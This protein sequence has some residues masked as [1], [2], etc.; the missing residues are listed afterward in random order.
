MQSVGDAMRRFKGRDA[1][2]HVATKT[3]SGTTP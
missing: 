3:E 2:R 1:A